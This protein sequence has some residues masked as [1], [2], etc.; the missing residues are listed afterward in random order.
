[1]GHSWGFRSFFPRENASLASLFP[2]SVRAR[3]RERGFVELFT[4]SYLIGIKF[5][6]GVKC[7]SAIS[8]R[9]F[10]SFTL[11]HLSWGRM[12]KCFTDCTEFI[13]LED[14]DYKKA[15]SNIIPC[16]FVTH[17]FI[18]WTR[19]NEVLKTG[20]RY[21]IISEI[22]LSN[23]NVKYCQLV[24]QGPRCISR[25]SVDLTMQH[26]ANNKPVWTMKTVVVTHITSDR[27]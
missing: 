3:V 17:W 22:I 4:K 5:L 19:S 11:R 7:C 9:P 12:H 25:I 16:Q 21:D 6:N 13:W 23:S 20:L 15:S 14:E 18:I 26:V 8:H 1:M 24:D 27:V 2:V 10:F